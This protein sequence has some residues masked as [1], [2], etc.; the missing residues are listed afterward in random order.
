[1]QHPSEESLEMYSMG[2]LPDSKTGPL[3]EH[4]LVCQL[5][6]ERLVATDEFVAAM[7]AAAA[8]IRQEERKADG[9]KERRHREHHHG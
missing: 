7:R 6:R 1:M 8:T 5:C 3:E 2:S 9:L 4:L